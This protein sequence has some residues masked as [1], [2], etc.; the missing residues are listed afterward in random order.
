MA[1]PREFDESEVLDRALQTFWSKGY[2]GTSIQDLVDATGLGRASLY[3]AF[4]DKEQL[5]RRVL[6]RYL[7]RMADMDALAASA[8]TVRGGFEAIFKIWIGAT[9]QKSG[10][11]GCFLQL[12]GTAGGDATFARD[13]LSGSLRHMERLFVE[14]V[15]RGQASG[16]LPSERDA[17]SVARLLVVVV[18]GLGTLA[19]AGWGQ[20]RLR[21]A[22]EEALAQVLTTSD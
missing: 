14:L 6:D 19:R 1:R 5:Y 13:T 9:C 21:S 3:G 2:E 8:P 18:Q 10:P 20:E 7:E 16:E 11:R 15:K 4:G 12:A 22:V 17:T